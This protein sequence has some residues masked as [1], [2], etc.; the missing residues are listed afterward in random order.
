MYRCA[1]V[2]LKTHSIP[3]GIVI[4]IIMT[5]RRKATIK[6]NQ[7]RIP[8]F[9]Y[10][11]YSSVRLFDRLAFDV[12]QCARACRLKLEYHKCYFTNFCIFVTLIA[13]I[14]KLLIV[15]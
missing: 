3:F 14:F 15:L 1:K 7:N 2:N 6:W 10:D 5:D 11:T 8:I 4:L 13:H 12:I 9:Y